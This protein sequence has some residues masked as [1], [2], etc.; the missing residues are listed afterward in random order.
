MSSIRH[1]NKEV[2]VKKAKEK[3]EDKGDF[4]GYMLEDGSIISGDQHMNIC[5]IW[6]DEEDCG[7]DDIVMFQKNT[8]TIRINRSV[9]GNDLY[10]SLHTINRI[11]GNQE[12]RI[13][14]QCES[15]NIN[16]ISIDVVNDN[17]YTIV[18]KEFPIVSC[19]RDVKVIVKKIN[20]DKF[21]L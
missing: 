6:K 18:S 16:S 3:F 12:K 21:G 14:E 1:Y 19:K 8:N 17:Y 20:E 4:D 13:I 10:L 15:E 11:T 5:K 2:L 9:K 7:Y